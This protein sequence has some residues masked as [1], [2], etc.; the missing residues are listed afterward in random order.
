GHDHGH[1]HEGHD[2]HHHGNPNELDVVV[3]PVKS[4]DEKDLAAA[5]EA[6]VV[7]FSDWES[8]TKDG[9]TIGPGATLHRLVL[10]D[11]HGHYKLNI[12]HAGHFVVFEGCGEDPLHIH[13]G[14]D[15]VKPDWQQDF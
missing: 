3:M 2:H 10:A 4:L 5:R 9:D 7:V 13:V 8:R 14:D 15:T 1:D 12:P 6:A 11:G